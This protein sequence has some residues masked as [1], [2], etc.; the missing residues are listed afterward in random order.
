MML[1]FT[2]PVENPNLEMEFLLF[3]DDERH[4]ANVVLSC[5]VSGI[6][7]GATDDELARNILW[8]EDYWCN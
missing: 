6:I 1:S 5:G 4:C 8:A 3:G 2:S 7:C